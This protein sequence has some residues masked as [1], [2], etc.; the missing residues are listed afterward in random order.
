MTFFQLANW[1][2]NWTNKQ[3]VFFFKVAETNS[4]KKLE[5]QTYEI[6][7]WTLY[8][9]DRFSMEEYKQ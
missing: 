3:F 8:K 6:I 2:K 7:W 9:S 1:E 5:L 4:W